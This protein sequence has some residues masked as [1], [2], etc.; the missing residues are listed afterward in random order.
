MTLKELLEKLY[1]RSISL[2]GGYYEPNTEQEREDGGLMLVSYACITEL[3]KREQ[4]LVKSNSSLNIEVSMLAERIKK[5]EQQIARLKT[6]PMKYRRMEFNAQLQRE[7]TEQAA[8]ISRLKALVGKCACSLHA[9][10]KRANYLDVLDIA[11]EAN[12]A[13][14]AIKEEGL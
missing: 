5:L 10:T 4:L 9:I 11:R 14:A 13:L 1:L 6:V 8:E 2:C 12:E 7:N 3:D